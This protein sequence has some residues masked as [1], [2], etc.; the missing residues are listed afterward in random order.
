MHVMYKKI[1]FHCHKFC[2]NEL[3]NSIR[4]ALYVHSSFF[5]FFRNF[6]EFFILF[7]K[8]K[9]HDLTSDSI[10]AFCFLLNTND[11]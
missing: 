8:I 1:V 10:C 3:N 2:D 11:C 4:F 5:G 6:K 7:Y 9:L